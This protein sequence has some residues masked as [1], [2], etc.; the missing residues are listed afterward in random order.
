MNIKQLE[1]FYWIERL[2]SFTAAAERLNA[3]QSTVSMRIQ[4]LEQ[5]LGVKLFDRSHRTARLTPK[6][7]ELVFYAEQLVEL[8]AE[9]QQRI[10]PPDSL[11]GLIRVGVVE[12]IAATWLPRFIRALQEE[13][14]GVKLELEVALTFELSEKL[15][16]G[17]LDVVF[18]LGRPPGTNYV[19][20]PLGSIQLEWMAHPGLGIPV[21]M[22]PAHELQRWPFITLNRLSYHHAKIDAWMKANKV[23]CRRIITCN[24]MTVAATLVAAGIGLSL[25]PPV[26]HRREI[27][28]GELRVV[29]TPGSLPPVDLFGM[30]PMDEFQP[31][32]RLVTDLAARVSG[33]AQSVPSENQSAAVS[34]QRDASWG[35]P[36]KSPTLPRRKLAS[37]ARKAE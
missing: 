29:R 8:T 16:N 5:S 32:A 18:A 21:G 6:G 25:L 17:T 13:Y 33:A 15:R 37:V 4:E 26:C 23:R 12:I 34:D 2:G 22:I 7:K 28:Q 10:T 31:L 35:G 19:V 14:P 11:S 20:E 24:S 3:T 27:E 36:V 1:T 9:M 30:Y